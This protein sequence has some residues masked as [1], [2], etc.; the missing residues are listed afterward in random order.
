MI[1][2]V[3]KGEMLTFVKVRALCTRTAVR[4]ALTEMLRFAKVWRKNSMEL[5]IKL[6]VITVGTF[7]GHW[8]ARKLDK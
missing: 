1:W 2:G 7:L 4:A 5:I 3:L 8:I 6:L